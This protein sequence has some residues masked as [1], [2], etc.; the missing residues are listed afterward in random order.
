MILVIDGAA[1]ELATGYA[2]PASDWRRLSSALFRGDD[3][4]VPLADGS[5]LWVNWRNV[6]TVEQLR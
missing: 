3:E 2:G 6:G 1:H 4:V 5:E